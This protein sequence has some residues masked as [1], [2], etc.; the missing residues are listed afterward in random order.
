MQNYL[1]KYGTMQDM[2]RITFL[3]YQH[4]GGYFQAMKHGNIKMSTL[5]ALD[6]ET[7]MT[8]S[9][10]IEHFEATSNFNKLK[11]LHIGVI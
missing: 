4:L 8:L 11:S 6:I 7:C 3:R 1:G 2:Q 10:H 5:H 9:T